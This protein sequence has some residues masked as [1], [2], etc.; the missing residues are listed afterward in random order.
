MKEEIKQRLAK[1]IL[2]FMN[3]YLLKA[4]EKKDNNNDNKEENLTTTNIQQNNY[5]QNNL[6]LDEI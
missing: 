2:Q 1:T 6:N 4:N 3:L 5:S